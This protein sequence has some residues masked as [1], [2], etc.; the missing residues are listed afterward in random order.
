MGAIKE[1]GTSAD[2]LGAATDLYGKQV[3][4]ERAISTD[5]EMFRQQQQANLKNELLRSA[6]YSEKEFEQNVLMPYYQTQE[7]AARQREAAN[8]NLAGALESV[9]QLG[10]QKMN[11]D[12]QKEQ[13]K[14]YNDAM[15]KRML[16]QKS[17][18][19]TTSTGGTGNGLTNQMLGFGE[20]DLYRI[21]RSPDTL[22]DTS[23]MSGGRPISLNKKNWWE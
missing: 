2:I 10:L 7:A 3:E 19:D 15:M 1:A 12:F 14:I 22:M 20:Q 11:Y 18:T 9:G 5:D 23:K 16:G 13:L 21:N 6:G 8:Q 17:N 4:T